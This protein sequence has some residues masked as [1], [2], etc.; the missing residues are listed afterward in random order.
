MIDWRDILEAHG[1][2]VWR[3]VY[4]LLAHQADAWDCYQ[5][6]FLSAYQAAGRRPVDHWPSFL[7]SL[8]TR[9]AIDRL[10]QRARTRSRFSPLDAIPEPSVADVSPVEHAQGDECLDRVR[11]LLSELP[12]KQAEVFWLSGVEGISHRD[13]GEQLGISDGEVRVLLHRAR[14]WLR[15]RLGPSLNDARSRP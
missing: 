8:A 11:S 6:T 1:P 7:T 10:R 3:T 12:R 4:R 5:E 15:A 2:A 14:A 9:R 13:I